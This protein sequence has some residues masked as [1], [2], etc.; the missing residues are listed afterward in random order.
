M[1]KESDKISFGEHIINITLH[2]SGEFYYSEASLGG[3]V[4]VAE[5]RMTVWYVQDG[6]LIL[7]GKRQEDKRLFPLLFQKFC[8]SRTFEEKLGRVE[9]P[10]WILN[11]RFE[12]QPFPEVIDPFL[13]YETL[14]VESLMKGIVHAKSAGVLNPPLPSDKIPMKRMEKEFTLLGIE[15][16]D[17]VSDLS[18]ID[19][20]SDGH[21]SIKE[22]M[23]L[24]M[25]GN[26]KEMATLANLEELREALMTSFGTLQKAFTELAGEQTGQLKLAEFET[27]LRALAGKET[28]GDVPQGSTDSTARLCDWMSE[29]SEQTIPEVFNALDTEKTGSLDW[30]DFCSLHYYG[31][32]H[33]LSLVDHF[34]GYLVDFFGTGPNESISS[35]FVTLSM[36]SGQNLAKADFLKACVQKLHYPHTIAAEAAFGILDRNFNGYINRNDFAYLKKFDVKD[37]T[38][39]LGEFVFA[40]K[41]KFETIDN[42]WNKV[43]EE[44]KKATGDTDAVSF[45]IF[46]GMCQKYRIH[47]RADLRQMFLFLDQ[48]TGARASG[49]LSFKEFRLLRGF[50]S[51]ATT[52]VPARLRKMLVTK[53]G[54]LE[55]AFST[56]YD[57][58]LPKELR[59][60]VEALALRQIVSNCGFVEKTKKNIGALR[61]TLKLGN[62]GRLS[63]AS[64]M[65]M[66][67]QSAGA[68]PSLPGL[69]ASAASPHQKKN[70]RRKPYIP[71][72]G[73]VEITKWEPSYP[74]VF[75]RLRP[76]PPHFQEGFPNNMSFPGGRPATMSA[77]DWELATP[78]LAATVVHPRKQVP[79]TTL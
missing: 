20:D 13:G 58:W 10:L 52:G 26:V 15:V 5:R 73:P 48:I 59:G 72:D 50:E 9:I 3:V 21:I 4:T 24:D 61:A 27:R 64:R 1:K 25:Y 55:D 56:V 12:Y 40:V 43:M 29:A 57:A 68:L 8:N 11:E 39:G 22:M 30:Q 41:T 46:E 70:A 79:W 62:F 2:V 6:M 37:F 67:T 35:A 75:H 49:K 42:F 65:S 51:R 78:S 32:R 34:R 60:R 77:I 76:R 17:F 19:T 16:S 69:N 31:A 54:S 63:Q 14:P 53:F 18:C 47:S 36:S 71:P 45:K 7:A 66:A 74:D 28:P 23:A 33:H 44:Q 38:D